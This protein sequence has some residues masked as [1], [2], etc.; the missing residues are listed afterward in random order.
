M[1]TGEERMAGALAG[2]MAAKRRGEEDLFGD[3]DDDGDELRQVDY[4]DDELRVTERH[5][6]PYID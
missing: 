3:D 4:D 2:A 1:V 5:V 6:P